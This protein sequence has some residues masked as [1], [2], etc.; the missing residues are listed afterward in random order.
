[1]AM[2]PRQPLMKKVMKMKTILAVILLGVF[3]LLGCNT[4]DRKVTE[5]DVH[6]SIQA[7]LEKMF[8]KGRDL[9]NALLLVHSDKHDF[10]WKFA[11][12]TTADEQKPIGKNNPY[13]VASIGKTFTSMIIARLYEGG[14]INYDDPISKYLSP[15]MLDGLFVYKGTDYSGEVLVR[16]LL[17]HTSGIAD[18]YEDKP[19]EGKSIKELI[20]ENPDR[21]WRPEDT[22]EFTRNNQRAVSVPGK[23]FHYSDTGYNLLG[24]IIEEITQK[25]FH[26]NLHTE[27][28]D[29][30]GM[31]SSYLLFYSK[32]KEKSPHTVPDTYLGE[33]EVSDFKSLSI[34]WAGG[35]IVSTTE[36]LLLF[37]RALVNNTLI[38]KETLELC[39]EDLGKFSFGMDYGYG[40][41]L[42]NIGKLTVFLPKDLNMW[43]NFGSIAAYMFYNPSHEVYIIGTFN[44]SDYV[45]KQVFFM[46]QVIREVS[47]L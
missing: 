37:H 36:D 43:G 47:K 38:K 21:F 40:I 20:V 39:K 31:V 5:N 28:F 32:P 35:G 24:K 13:H 2:I 34:D 33:H 3:V 15:E 18:Y 1:M 46:I 10:H 30:L 41:L 17:N 25:P 27:I 7:E 8:S 23:K 9:K 42:L 11:L 4:T 19:M 16:H 12:G 45:V 22:I 14:E 26:E 6:D 44:H 29:P